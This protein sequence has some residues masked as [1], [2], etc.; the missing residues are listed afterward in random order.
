M[1]F[2]I[3]QST[4]KASITYLIHDPVRTLMHSIEAL[5]HDVTFHQ[6]HFIVDRINIIVL[7][8]RLSEKMVNRLIES[9]IQYIVYQTEVFSEHGVNYIKEWLAKSVVN[10]HLQEVYLRLLKNALA[11]WECFDFNQK[12]LLERGINSQIIHHGYVPQLEGQPKKGNLY[13]VCFFG[14]MTDYR[15]EILKAMHKRG[16]NIHVLGAGPPFVR[17][18]LLRMSKINLSI[19]ANADTMSHIPHFRILTAL[20]HNTMTISEYAKG[21]QWLEPMMTYVDPNIEDLVNMVEQVLNEGTY[22][23]KA[24]EY[25]RVFQSKPMVDIMRELLDTL[26]I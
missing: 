4:R 6:D 14:S 7:G 19:R 15:Q 1:K 22:E 20:Y 9:K 3:V 8:F 23:Q 25:K 2:N 10:I 12:F 24:I 11:V 16:I 21:Q 18:E 17:D 26:S 5:G 13:D